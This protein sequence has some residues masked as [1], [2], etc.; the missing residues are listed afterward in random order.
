MY[1]HDTGDSVPG[2]ARVTNEAGEVRTCP[3]A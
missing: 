2:L 3:R 1:L